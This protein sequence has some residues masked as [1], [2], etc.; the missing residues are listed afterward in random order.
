MDLARDLATRL[1]LDLAVGDLARELAGRADEQPLAYGERALE[2]AADL[3][4]FDLGRA[5]E[6][7]GLGDFDDPAFGQR[8]FDAAFDDQP[9]ARGDLAG[10]HD[11]AA[12]DELFALRRGR[13]IASARCALARPTDAAAADDR[14][15]RL[16]EC[17]A[18][19]DRRR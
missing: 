11:L 16:A 4:A 18:C 2:A 15:G 5:L 9:V 19:A 6:V 1:D 10:E 8:G 17:S 13:C 14:A 12:D 3:G 7:A